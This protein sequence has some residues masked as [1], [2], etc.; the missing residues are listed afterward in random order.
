M[1]GLNIILIL[2]FSISLYGS[3]ID[4]SNSWNCDDPIEIDGDWDFYWMQL[5]DGSYPSSD[6]KL[7]LPSFWQNTMIE[8]EKLKSFG[9]AS[10]RKKVQI[11]N[12]GEEVALFLEHIHSAYKVIVNDK[13]L[14]ESGKVGESKED[15]VPHRRPI[16]IPLPKT[17]YFDIVIQISNFDHYRG[18]VVR[19]PL[20]V[21][22]ESYTTNLDSGRFIDTFIA[23]GT[24]LIGVTFLFIFLFSRRTGEVFFFSMLSITLSVRLL[25]A[26]IYPLHEIIDVDD[27][28]RWMIRV[29]YTALFLLSVFGASYVSF[30]FPNNQEKKFYTLIAI[31]GLLFSLT[32]IFGPIHFFTAIIPTYLLTLIFLI[33]VISLTVI[34]GLRSG[35]RS[36]WILAVGILFSLLWAIMDSFVYFGLLD[37]NKLLYSILFM[38][39]VFVNNIALMDR[40]AHELIVSNKKQSLIESAESRK[41]LMSMISHEIK[42][43]VA[44][45][46]M[47]YEMLELSM[48]DLTKL[49]YLKH[50][51]LPRLKKSIESIKKMLNDFVYFMNISAN[52][53]EVCTKSKIQEVMNSAFEIKIIDLVKYEFSFD[54]NQKVLIYAISTFISNAIKYT[55]KSNPQPEL[56]IYNQ[57]DRYGIEIKD[58][59]VG[60]SEEIL[61]KM[62]ELQMDTSDIMEVHGV[63]FYLAKKLLEM[64]GHSV[65][66]ESTVGMGTSVRISLS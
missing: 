52:S 28:F 10:I 61:S 64:I 63:G 3:S 12:C 16:I 51:I 5:V 29:E 31:V 21:N 43:P 32:A 22:K 13:V 27:N 55:P 65:N 14:Y 6:D 44:Q 23:G 9:Y 36:A 41:L 20:I 50:R 42:T 66:I 8:G 19:T 62:G 46:Q 25:M 40:F 2:L 26:G 38:A 34:K 35:D 54:T 58:Y 53:T 57:D 60:M 49:D 7:S 4:L 17:N 15:Y 56:K 11:P 48:S 18:G 1:K 45:L 39:F 24:G 47:N 37:S 30:L 59:G 33:F